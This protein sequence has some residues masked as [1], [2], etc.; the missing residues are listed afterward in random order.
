MSKHWHFAMYIY[1]NTSSALICNFFMASTKFPAFYMRP[2]GLQNLGFLLHKGCREG[3][4]VN[5]WK[6][7]FQLLLNRKSLD[8]ASIIRQKK[9]IRPLRH[10]KAKAHRCSETWF[11]QSYEDKL[12]HWWLLAATFLEISCFF[13]ETLESEILLF[14][15]SRGELLLG[16]LLD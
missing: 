2:K 1:G 3:A 5:F 14:L 11:V 12:R 15:V 10:D 9:T 7:C 4:E 8:F 16:G 6:W 13:F